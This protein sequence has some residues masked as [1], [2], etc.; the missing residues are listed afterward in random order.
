[1]ARIRFVKAPSVTW[2]A[3]GTGMLCFAFYLVRI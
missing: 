1:M 2:I 3:L